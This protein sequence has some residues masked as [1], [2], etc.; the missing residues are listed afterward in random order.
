MPPKKH[1]IIIAVLSMI[2]MGL[3]YWYG[4]LDRY[5]KSD[6]KIL[7]LGLIGVVWFACIR[8]ILMNPIKITRYPKSLSIGLG[9]VLSA[10]MG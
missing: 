3:G 6:Y 8:L 7:L 5:E 1:I 2:S 4:G 9:Q 10:G